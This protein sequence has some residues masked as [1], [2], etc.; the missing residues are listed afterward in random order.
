MTTGTV[1]R[2][3]QSGSTLSGT[4]NANGVATTAYFEYGTTSTYGNTT[5]AQSI[6]ASRTATPFS[7]NLTNL[8]PNTTYHYRLV[9][10]N[11]GGTTR[12]R[13][14]SVH[15]AARGTLRR[16][17]YSEQFDRQR[18]DITRRGK[19][20]R[21]R[22]RRALRV[23]HDDPLRAVH[24]RPE[25]ARREQHR[26][27]RRR[28]LEFGARDDLPF[29]NGGD[30]SRR[31]KHWGRSYFHDRAGPE[32]V[33]HR[34]WRGVCQRRDAAGRGEP[35]SGN[36][37]GLLRIWSDEQLRKHDADAERR[38]RRDRDQRNS[39]GCRPDTVDYVSLPG[40]GRQLRW[41]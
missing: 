13:G 30:E 24:T 37:P 8:A 35:K 39:A 1:G 6:G 5:P 36:D 23:W 20:K 14:C 40:R 29:S 22:N 34:R 26:G 31:N 33:N 25:S 9:A 21:W 38:Q 4:V 3:T 12:G 17:C 41:G 10:V 2:I 19:S 18:S 11:A 32:C 28:D 15:H 7:Q 16:Y 27:Y